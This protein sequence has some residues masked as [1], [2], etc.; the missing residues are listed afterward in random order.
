MVRAPVCSNSFVAA[1]TD[2]LRNTT[3]MRRGLLSWQK[4]GYLHRV[5][6]K[7]A[8]LHTSKARSSC[9]Q[10]AQCT[11]EDSAEFSLM[12]CQQA[13]GM[14]FRVSPGQLVAP[15]L[16]G[17]LLIL[18]RALGQKALSRR[19]QSTTQWHPEWCPAV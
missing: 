11:P 5:F 1:S 3:E 13:R 7:A 2:A 8:S 4:S 19:E 16:G 14:P 10:E 12:H 18:L 9:L 15:I 6:G 17:P